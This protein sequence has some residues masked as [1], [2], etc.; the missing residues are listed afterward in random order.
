MKPYILFVLLLIGFSASMVAQPKVVLTSK[1][2]SKEASFNEM[3]TESSKY[4]KQSDA[5]LESIEKLTSIGKKRER[6]STSLVR[7]YE[8]TRLMAFDGMESGYS[9][10]F[11][12]YT[13]AIKKANLVALNSKVDNMVAGAT[14]HHNT[15]REQFRK[16][17]NE[18]DKSKSVKSFNLGL[19]SEKS[20]IALLLDAINLLEGGVGRSEAVTTLNSPVVP[21]A[22][23][24]IDTMRPRPTLTA[25]MPVAMMPTRI[26]STSLQ[27]NEIKSYDDTKTFFSIQI[28]ASK[29][30][31]SQAEISSLYRGNYLVVLVEADGYYRYSVGKFLTLADAQ[32][33]VE[34]EKI[35]GYIVGY[36]NYKRSSIVEVSK[37]LSLN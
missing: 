18:M 11:T 19:N 27:I 30:K 2:L 6:D 24:N 25:V 36:V 34:K 15:A 22:T 28:T 20:S 3:I 14:L 35:K 26:D 4:L 12:L 23:V 29:T 21:V 31:L 16:V 7:K 13:N 8:R 5:A 9:S 33:I 10:L 37:A 32:A 17:P 1:D